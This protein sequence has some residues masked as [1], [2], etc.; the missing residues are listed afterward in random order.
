MFVDDVEKLEDL[1]VCGLIELEIEATH[2]I[3]SFYLKPIRRARQGCSRNFGRCWPPLPNLAPLLG[4]WLS[5]F[6]E[7]AST[8]GE[9][10][11]A[12]ECIYP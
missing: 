4:E 12:E 2:V 6:I 10:Q 11:E 8:T 5:R 3:R 7:G 9:T 1:A